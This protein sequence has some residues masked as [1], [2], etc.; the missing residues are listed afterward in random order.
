MVLAA[1]KD[2]EACNVLGRGVQEEHCASRGK[3]ALVG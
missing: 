3:T 1:L 2:V